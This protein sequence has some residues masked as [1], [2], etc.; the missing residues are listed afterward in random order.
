MMFVNVGATGTFIVRNPGPR[1]KFRAE[2][3]R[4]L[5]FEAEV[6]LCDGRDLI[7]LEMENPFETQPSGP[8]IVRFASI[9]S[10]PGRVPIDIP[11]TLPPP[12]ECFVR[13]IALK[14]RFV[15]GVYRRHLRT[16]S[17]LSQ[18]DKLFGVPATTRTCCF[19]LMTA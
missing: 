3:L 10:R 11:F 2:L 6:V 13:V 9:L 12:G 17:Y 8:D 4:Q 1:A 16:I 19:N 15:L 5:P 14:K 18:I 7:R